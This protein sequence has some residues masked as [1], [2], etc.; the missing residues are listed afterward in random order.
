MT[1]VKSLRK[2]DTVKITI[3][4]QVETVEPFEDDPHGDM[5][6]VRLVVGG[7]RVNAN[8]EWDVDTVVPH[9]EVVARHFESG[10]IA[11]LKIKHIPLPFRVIFNG[12]SQVWHDAGGRTWSATNSVIESVKLLLAA[13]APTPDVIDWVDR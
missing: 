11:L 9:I 3:E 10:D 4:G 12:R 7:E 5:V 13:D 6:Q 2:G 8:I 1:D